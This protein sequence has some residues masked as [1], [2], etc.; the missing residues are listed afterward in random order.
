MKV[1]ENLAET[2]AASIIEEKILRKDELKIKIMVLLKAMTDV[3]NIERSSRYNPTTLDYVSS[4][5][6]K[7]KFMSN[8]WRGKLEI[9]CP[10]KMKEFNK[11]LGELLKKSDFSSKR[12]KKIKQ[13][14]RV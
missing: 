14:V 5:A 9:N 13:Y 10:E 1:I 2:I 11:E 8:F 7:N 4:V 3:K 6:N 12:E